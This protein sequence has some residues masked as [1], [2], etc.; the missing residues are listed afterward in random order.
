ME[1]KKT[2]DV[3]IRDEIIAVLQDIYDP[4]IPVDIYALGLIYDVLIDDEKNVKIIMTLTAANC[5]AAQSLPNQVQ[6]FVQQI[7]EVNEVEV[8]IVWEPRWTPEMMSEAAR[9]QLGY[10]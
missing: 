10:F 3:S 6:F 9:L 4:E 7:P 8:E 2:V 5:P 1:L